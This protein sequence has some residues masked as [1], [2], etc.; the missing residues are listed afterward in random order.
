MIVRMS[1]SQSRA[2]VASWAISC[3]KASSSR[4][5]SGFTPAI[6]AYRIRDRPA[7]DRR[8]LRIGDRGR[9]GL[10]ERIGPRPGGPRVLAHGPVPGGL[11]PQRQAEDLDESDR[12]GM[13][14]RV[15]FVVRGEALVV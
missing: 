3:R 13:I 2:S 7:S 5:R 11:D 10:E 12:R 15:A 6:M 9:Q 8:R 14:E 4:R 1:S